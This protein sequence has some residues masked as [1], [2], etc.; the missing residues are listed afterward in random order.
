MKFIQINSKSKCICGGFVSIYL[1][2]LADARDGRY[3]VQSH[4]HTAQC[5]I[6]ARF[7]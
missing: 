1:R 7:G 5:V 4:F 6:G 3:H 2:F